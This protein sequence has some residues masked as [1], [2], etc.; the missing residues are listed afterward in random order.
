MQSNRDKGYLFTYKWKK[1][2]FFQHANALLALYVSVL[3]IF[4]VIYV[5]KLSSMMT[6]S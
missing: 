1:S 4:K 5:S 3:R 6:T 2:G